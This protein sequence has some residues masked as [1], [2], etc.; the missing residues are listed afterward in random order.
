MQFAAL[1][2]LQKRL[3]AWG[4]A[5]A[6]DADS[7]AIRLTACRDYTNLADLK[8]AL[9]GNLQGKVLEI[10]PGAGVNLSYYP[11][12]IHWVGVEPNPYM[13]DYLRQ[14]ASKHRLSAIELHDSPAEALPFGE[15]TFDAVVS[16]HVLCSVTQLETALGEVWRV[17]KPGQP[18][19]FL[20]H[21]GADPGTWTRTVQNTV[22]PAWKAMFDN[23]HTNRETW[24]SLEAAGFSS[25]HYE[26]FRLQFPVVSPHI[27]G[28]AV[29]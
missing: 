19:I 18:F 10:G 16:T 22:A 6:N 3:F 25:C 13:H 14:E 21:V 5:K 20:E 11:A 27:A 12:A 29:K 1:S 23:C 28:V 17:L 26:Q 2:Q 24:K 9:L 8:Q 4:M 7:H 15:A